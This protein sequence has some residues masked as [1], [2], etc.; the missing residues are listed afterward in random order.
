MEEK[1]NKNNNIKL[2]PSLIKALR[3]HAEH[4]N[5][6]YDVYGSDYG[7]E[8]DETYEKFLGEYCKKNNIPP[9]DENEINDEYDGD[10]C[11]IKDEINDDG[12]GTGRY[13]ILYVLQNKNVCTYICIYPH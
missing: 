1:N 2:D 11:K 10:D 13:N 7:D 9:K 3:D 6:C 12:A 8:Y 4:Q 5:Y